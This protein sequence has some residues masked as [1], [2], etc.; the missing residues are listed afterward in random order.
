[1]TAVWQPAGTA[2]SASHSLIPQ[3][4]IDVNIGSAQDAA[5]YAMQYAS[6]DM[7]VAASLLS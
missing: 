3:S 4:V 2:L 1:L 5:M 6:H 7:R